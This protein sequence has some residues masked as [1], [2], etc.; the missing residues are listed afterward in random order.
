MESESESEWERTHKWS[1]QCNEEKINIT[2]IIITEIYRRRRTIA[3]KLSVSLVLNIS[4]R[5]YRQHIVTTRNFLCCVDFSAVG[6][7]RVRLTHRVEASEKSAFKRAN[8]RVRER[9]REHVVQMENLNLVLQEH[10]FILSP[11]KWKIN[12]VKTFLPSI[13]HT[14]TT[15]KSLHFGHARSYTIHSVGRARKT[16]A[17]AQAIE[18]IWSTV[19][20]TIK[21]VTVRVFVCSVHTE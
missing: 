5:K 17:L 2:V 4:F 12:I 18:I 1:K 8:E 6:T 14:T 11:N 7:Q 19:W 21:S 20:Q 10:L 9:E 16:C 15:T 13:H 3:A